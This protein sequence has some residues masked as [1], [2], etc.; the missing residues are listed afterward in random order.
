MNNELRLFFS[1][2]YKGDKEK[3]FTLLELLVA[4]AI[5]GLLSSLVLIGL[6]TTRSRSRDA[7]RIADVKT[8]RS[9]LDSYY[10]DK[11][12]YPQG[13]IS[14][15]GSAPATALLLQ[16]KTDLINSAL[17]ADKLIT[18]PISDPINGV[19]GGVTYGIYYNS[20]GVQS[21]KTP[22]PD[23]SVTAVRNNEYYAITFSLETDSF[24]SQGY[25]IGNNCVGP[26]INNLNK[27]LGSIFNGSSFCNPAP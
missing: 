24:A 18:T 13:M 1:D 21:D 14:C 10:I 12:E 26:K 15:P 16:D 19:L 25:K 5:I 9:A 6:N 3:G 17:I 4:I 27:D 2:I 11:K 7:R 22:D 23:S 20:C 8:L